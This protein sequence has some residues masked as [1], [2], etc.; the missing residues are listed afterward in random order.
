MDPQDAIAFNRDMRQTVLTEMLGKAGCIGYY[1]FLS[2]LSQPCLY[3]LALA[4]MAHRSMQYLEIPEI[5]TTW[6]KACAGP[7][8][9]LNEFPHF[10]QE[11]NAEGWTRLINSMKELSKEVLHRHGYTALANK[12]QTRLSVEDGKLLIRVLSSDL[13][14]RT[15]LFEENQGMC[16][17]DD[18]VPRDMGKLWVLLGVDDRGN[19]YY[20]VDVGFRKHYE[21]PGFPYYCLPNEP[22]P[23]RITGYREGGTDCTELMEAFARSLEFISSISTCA[24]PSTAIEPRERLITALQSLPPSYQ[25]QFLQSTI[26]DLTHM[27][28][29]NEAFSQKICCQGCNERL[30]IDQLS[31]HSKLSNPHALCSKCI[32][33]NENCPVCGGGFDDAIK[34]W[35]G[36]RLRG[37]R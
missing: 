5:M 34:S 12:L 22:I 4:V 24:L 21:C 37:S 16:T 13:L 6:E 2:T 26:A 18:L 8:S 17:L 3:A 9:V 10:H 28:H 25:S 7:L 36:S 20:F 30:V 31:W 15:I 32:N 14:F 11:L 27:S 1:Y 35:A 29:R 19:Y 33:Q 23:A